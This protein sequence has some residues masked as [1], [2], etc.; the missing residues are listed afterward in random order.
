MD[1]STDYLGLHLKNPLVASAS[2]LSRQVDRVRELEDAGIGAVVMFSL[3]EEEIRHESLQLHHYLEHGTQSFA[4]ALDYFPDHESYDVGP[5]A[6][7]EHLR[8]LKAAVGIPIIGSLNGTSLG[9]W[10]EYARRIEE[11]GAD[12]LELNVYYIPTE[13]TTTSQDVE[14]LYLDILREVKRCVG[15]PVAVKLSPYFSAM[16]HMAQQLDWNGADGLVLFNRFYQPDIDLESLRAFPHVLL[17]TPQALRLPLRWIAIL[18]G[19]I[20]ADLAAT[21]GVHSHEDVLKVLM[22]GAKVAM[23]ASA[24]LKHGP[25]HVRQLLHQLGDWMEEHEYESVRQLQGS[26]SQR[27]CANPTAFERANYLKALSTYI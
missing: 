14:Q 23:M 16:A 7:L 20:S 27:H 10:I 12:A 3:F 4:E 5:D 13:I 19:Q 6:Y 2:P 17:S 9:G 26:M 21:S 11:A 25:G 24:L 18:Y 15:I 22:A 1:L 8:Q